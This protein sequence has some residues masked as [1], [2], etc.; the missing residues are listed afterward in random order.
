VH[1]KLLKGDSLGNYFLLK[2]IMAKVTGKGT[3]ESPWELKT[4]AGSSAYTMFKNN[5][6]DPAILV[7]NRG[8]LMIFIQC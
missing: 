8:Q 1:L 7:Y 2:I 3:K 4:P 5:S 6:V